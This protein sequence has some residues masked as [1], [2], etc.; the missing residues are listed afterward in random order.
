M[1]ILTRCPAVASQ[2]WWVDQLAAHTVDPHNARG[3]TLLGGGLDHIQQLEGK[4]Q[5]AKVVAGHG[6]LEGEGVRE[7]GRSKWK[8]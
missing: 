6:H 7:K 1:F 2:V 3:G 5:G 4:V 8:L